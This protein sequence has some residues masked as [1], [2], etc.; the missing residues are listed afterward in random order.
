MN[1]RTS[2]LAKWCAAEDVNFEKESQFQMKNKTTKHRGAPEQVWQ[3]GAA[4]E[5]RA[6]KGVDDPWWVELRTNR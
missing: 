6:F 3:T 2:V 5:R 1:Q 4:E